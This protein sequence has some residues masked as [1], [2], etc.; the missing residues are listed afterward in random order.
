[1]AKTTEDPVLAA[2]LSAH[3]QEVEMNI[4][5]AIEQCDRQLVAELLPR[6]SELSK[7]EGNPLKPL[8]KAAQISIENKDLQSLKTI[9]DQ[10]RS[11]LF[12]HLPN[13]DMS[14]S[15]S[16]LLEAVDKGKLAVVKRLIEAGEDVN[17][18]DQKGWNCLHH[19]VIMNDVEIIEYLL[20]QGVL[21]NLPSRDGCTP[22]D[23]AILLVKAFNNYQI[24]DLLKNHGAIANAAGKCEVEIKKRNK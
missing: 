1:M 11:H 2:D 6:Y 13:N 23:F 17:T 15:G 22:L 24:Y 16:S 10:I 9:I 14:T 19:A 7:A 5:K 21:I 18:I 20:T 3:L 12:P 8:Q 4:L